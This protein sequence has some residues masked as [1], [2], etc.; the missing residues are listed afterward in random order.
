M[1]PAGF[2]YVVSGITKVVLRYNLSLTE[3]L[4]LGEAKTRTEAR[5]RTLL[6]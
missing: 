2:A 1:W 4:S 5:L 3:E 6:R